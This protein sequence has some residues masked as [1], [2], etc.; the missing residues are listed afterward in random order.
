MFDPSYR[1]DCSENSWQFL[2]EKKSFVLVPSRTGG[3]MNLAAA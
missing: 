2:A 3:V 1:T